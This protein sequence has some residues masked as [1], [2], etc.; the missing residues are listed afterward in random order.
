MSI[1]AGGTPKPHQ[2]ESG[3]HDLHRRIVVITRPVGTAAA[4]A[5]RVRAFGGDPML[6]PGLALRG[7]TDPDAARQALQ[8]ALGDELIIFTSPAAVRHAA[9]LAP[10]HTAATVLAVGQATATALNRR[11]LHSVL[12]PSRQD[13]EGLLGLSSLQDVAGRRVALVGAAGGREVL[14]VELVR[15][16]AQLREVQV[17][18][19]VAPRLDRRHADRLQQLPASALVLLSSAEALR[20]LHQLLPAS[21]W[22][23]LV[24]ATAV[25]SSD[26]LAEA[27]RELGFGRL[28]RAAS[29]NGGDMLQAALRAD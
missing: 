12:T 17:Y 11:G 1:T 8:A 16:G 29:A 22:A 10:L 2:P 24:S 15:R 23:R 18:R 25:V 4:L 5:R 6:L 26:R 14:R 28:L 7:A 21:A 27:A 19:R 9:L 3:S 20:W 13:S